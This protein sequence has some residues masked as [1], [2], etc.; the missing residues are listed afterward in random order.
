MIDPRFYEL[1]AHLWRGGAY[2]YFWSSDIE[3]EKYSY[4]LTVGKHDEVPKMFLGADAYFGVHP[5]NI[6]RSQNERAKITDIDCVN[7]FYVEYDCATPESKKAT[8]EKINSLPIK[9]AC[10]VDSGGGFHCYFWLR[11]TYHLDTLDKRQKAADLQWAFVQWAGGDSAVNDLARVLRIPGTQNHKAHFAPNYPTVTIVGWDTTQR[12]ELSDLEPILQPYI[13]ARAKPV[14]EAHTATS[15]GVSLSDSELL[16]VLFRSKNGAIYE[17]LWA[18]NLN[19][20][21]GDHSDCDQFLCNGLAWLT[22]RD[23][24]RMDS[25]FRQSGLYREKWETKSYRERTLK[26]AVTSAQQVYEPRH[27][28]KEAQAAAEAAVGVKGSHAIANPLTAQLLKSL[29]DFELSDHGNAEAFMHIYPNQFV[30]T[31]THGWLYYT[32]SFWESEGAKAAVKQATVETLRM[33]INTALRHQPMSS[34]KLIRFCTP[35]TS[36][37]E[38]TIKA[39]ESESPSKIKLFDNEPDLLNCLNGV[40]DLRTGQLISHDPSQ[41]FTYVVPVEYDPSADS[42][43]W[44]STLQKNTRPEDAEYLRLASGYSATGRTWEEILFYLYGPSRSGKGTFTE[45]LGNTLG[46]NLSR[47]LPF[48]TFTEKRS[49]D[50]QNFDLAPLKN[51]RMVFAS[52]AAEHE[53]LNEAKVKALTGGN[54]VNCAFKHQDFFEYRPQYKIWLSANV[55]PNADPTDDA[56][57]GRLRVIEFPNSHLGSEDKGLKEALRTPQILQGVLQWIVSGAVDWYKL[58]T[59]GLSESASM[60]QYKEKRRIDLDVFREWLVECVKDKPGNQEINSK[61]FMSYDLWCKNNGVVPKKNKGFTQ[62]MKRRGY[63]NHPT[64]IGMVWLNVDVK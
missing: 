47:E 57:W 29:M 4:W 21:N 44:V 48:T 43:I 49:G 52:E 8:L 3:G 28:D 30:Y 50:S 51:C 16:Q 55:E 12:H 38:A 35:N 25:L 27:V 19:A 13:D 53:R 64:N 22:G 54:K 41:L 31:E 10:I 62:E 60:N 33:R 14:M 1:T 9:P 37:V 11:D 32:G 34:D 23:S 15:H 59:K 46:G 5:S 42:E 36:R 17:G 26:N 61:V 24:G 7:T 45:T 2:S 58:G 40:V 18:G 63:V 6:R 20:H 56:V 39:L